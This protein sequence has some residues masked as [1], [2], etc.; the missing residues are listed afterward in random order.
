[1]FTASFHNTDDILG[2]LFLLK[3]HICIFTMPIEDITRIRGK[4]KHTSVEWDRDRTGDLQLRRPRTNQLDYICLSLHGRLHVVA[5]F[6]AA[7][8]STTVTF[9]WLNLTSP[10]AKHAC[11]SSWGLLFRHFENK[12]NELFFQWLS[13]TRPSTTFFHI[14]KLKVSWLSTD[15]KRT[16]LL[17][18]KH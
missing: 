5:Y 17:S 15:T 16:G 7:L 6:C 3:Y 14:S 8:F 2:F 4:S 9:L 18:W 12:W 13:V 11:S 10:F 1:M